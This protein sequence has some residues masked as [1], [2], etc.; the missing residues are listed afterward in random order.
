MAAN[1]AAISLFDL[2]RITERL[3]IAEL[4]A[5]ELRRIIFW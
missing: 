5:T 2:K 3:D 1:Q 4:T